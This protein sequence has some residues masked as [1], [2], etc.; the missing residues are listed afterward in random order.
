MSLAGD[1]G[2]P[3]PRFCPG[4]DPRRSY[5]AAVWEQQGPVEAM[6]RLPG[7]QAGAGGPLASVWGINASWH[8]VVPVS[9]GAFPSPASPLLTLQAQPVL[10]LNKTII[11]TIQLSQLLNHLIPKSIPW[12][13]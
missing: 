10:H 6:V 11:K 12:V 2:K 1:E 8:P 4:R 7:S 3:P 9:I 5:H 13:I